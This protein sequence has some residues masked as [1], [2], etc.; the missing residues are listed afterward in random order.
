MPIRR[1][2]RIPR[3]S[4]AQVAADRS[5]TTIAQALGRALREARTSTLRSQRAVADAAG[6]AHSTVS[7]AERGNG[8][9]FTLR[10]W[11]RLA[12]ASGAAL[13]AYIQGVSDADRPRDAVHLR[14]QELILATAARGGWQGMTEAPIDDPARGS[15]F[16]D[17]ALR[18]ALEG[19]MEVAVIEVVDWQDDVGATLRDWTRRVA[20]VERRATGTLTRDAAD[21]Q[22]IVP[23]VAGCLVLRATR[24]NRTLVRD[25]RL[26]FRTRFPGSGTAWLKALES[27]SPMPEEAAILWVSVDGSRLWPARL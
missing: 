3:R 11:A 2:S 23:S 22:P 10:T 26:V 5:A 9:D 14:V 16:L 7:E 21:G 18:R 27:R 17:V 12:I 19:L 8:D 4:S 24:R 25:H 6:M 13:R 20:R 1:R 15:R